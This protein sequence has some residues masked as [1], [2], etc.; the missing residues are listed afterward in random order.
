MTNRVEKKATFQKRVAEFDINT[1]FVVLYT[2]HSADSFLVDA[3]MEQK[4][5]TQSQIRVMQK[6]TLLRHLQLLI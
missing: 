4:G 2:H 3:K 1:P 5:H 6:V